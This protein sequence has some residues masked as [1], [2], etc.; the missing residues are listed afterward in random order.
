MIERVRKREREV[1]WERERESSI[2]FLDSYF[3]K[4]WLHSQS[5]ILTKRQ[6]MAKKSKAMALNPTDTTSSN[7]SSRSITV[8][9]DGQC[10]KLPF[11]GHYIFSSFRVGLNLSKI[12]MIFV[13]QPKQSLSFFLSIKQTAARVGSPTLPL[14]PSSPWVKSKI[15]TF[16]VV[17]L[18]TNKNYCE[19]DGMKETNA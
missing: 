9:C 5:G 13:F 15:G 17:S 14:S 18:H 7:Y 1:G 2:K 4:G 11:A 3:E 16:A 12:Q 10:G 8:Q 6:N 19:K